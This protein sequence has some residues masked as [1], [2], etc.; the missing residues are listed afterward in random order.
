M[1][2]TLCAAVA[3][4]SLL[5]GTPVFAH[6]LLK[7]SVPKNGTTVSSPRQLTMNFTKPVRLTA[8]NLS[9]SGKQVP[10]TRDRATQAT[11]FSFPV[12]ALAPGT[13]QVRWTAMA[14]DGH[15]MSGELSFAVKA[16]SQASKARV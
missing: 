5:A 8:V 16:A 3:A 12:P 6:S 14:R 9:R 2:K 7:S 1:W 10:L 15:V 13:Y 4:A 11:S